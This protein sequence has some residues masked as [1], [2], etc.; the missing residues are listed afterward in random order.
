MLELAALHLERHN[1][2]KASSY[3]Q[4]AL[5]MQPGNPDATS[6][7]VRADLLR[8]DVSK[9]A[10]DLAP[11]QKALPTTIGVFKLT[12]LIQLASNHPDA[13]GRSYERVLR[14]DA[15]NLEALDALVTIDLKSGHAHDAAA[16][17]D[18]RLKVAAPT[19]ALLVLAATAHEAAGD[20]EVAEMLLR[21]AIE[22]D[23]DRL[24]AYT[25][26]GALYVRQHRLYDATESFRQVLTRNPKS[27]SAATMVGML[28]EAQGKSADAEQQYRQVLGLDA[29]AAVA[30]NNLA[31]IYVA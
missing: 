19:V 10:A 2:D 23:P 22:A 8:G 24:V 11:L 3:A 9:A 5:T 31:W 26:L 28:L 14:A 12:A 4:Q 25:R 21:R 13:A 7:L 6:L 15:N 17:M 18:A 1:V 29:H 16:R 20:L 27:V 30:A